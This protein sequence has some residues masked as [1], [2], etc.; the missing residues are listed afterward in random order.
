MQARTLGHLQFF[1]IFLDVFIPMSSS[2][3]SASRLLGDP[4][5]A[6]RYSVARTMRHLAASL[7]AQKAAL[8]ALL[9]GAGHVPRRV[10]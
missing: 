7:A 2:T 10:A 5:A 4:D 3:R 6:L 8:G 9:K 1:F